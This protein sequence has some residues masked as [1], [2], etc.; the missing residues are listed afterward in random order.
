MPIGQQT[1]LPDFKWSIYGNNNN[2]NNNKNGKFVLTRQ[3][4]GN[5]MFLP[6]KIMSSS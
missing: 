1:R 5:F 3:S 4:N 2:K 6:Q